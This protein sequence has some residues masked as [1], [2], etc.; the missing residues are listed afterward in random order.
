MLSTSLA[1]LI[2]VSK[3]EKFSAKTGVD[4]KDEDKSVIQ[5]EM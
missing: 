5:E 1:E 2:V 3:V 4:M